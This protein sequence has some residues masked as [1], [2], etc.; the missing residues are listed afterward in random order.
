MLLFSV[1]AIPVQEGLTEQS[2]EK[3]KNPSK[4]ETRRNKYVSISA[5]Y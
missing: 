5:V 3:E 2:I 1:I 4:P